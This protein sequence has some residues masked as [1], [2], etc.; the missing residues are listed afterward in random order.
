MPP[1][2]SA[3]ASMQGARHLLGHCSGLAQCCPQRLTSGL[4][5]LIHHL[6]HP[7]SLGGGSPSAMWPLES[8]KTSAAV[9]CAKYTGAQ[10]QGRVH[11]VVFHHH[12]VCSSSPVLLGCPHPST[13]C[14]TDRPSAWLPQSPGPQPLIKLKKLLC[15][16]TKT[17]NRT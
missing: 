1:K 17:S 16:N 4:P 10:A 12:A 7:P 5:P 14:E 2:F 3:P 13:A 8:G 11:T 9:M 15:I 6:G